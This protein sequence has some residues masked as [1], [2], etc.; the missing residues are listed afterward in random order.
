MGPALGSATQFTRLWCNLNDC[1]RCDR[2]D[3]TFQE[4]KAD[5]AREHLVGGGGDAPWKT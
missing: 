3:G 2:A 5:G 1:Y 4:G